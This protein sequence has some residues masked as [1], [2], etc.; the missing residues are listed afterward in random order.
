MSEEQKLQI[1]RAV[2][3]ELNKE[4]SKK[5]KKLPK[6]KIN[7]L[8]PSA[9]VN[10]KANIPQP[11]SV[12]AKLYKPKSVSK[13]FDAQ[14]FAG[15]VPHHKTQRKP[16]KRVHVTQ[17]TTGDSN[18]PELLEYKHMQKFVD[19]WK[20]KTFGKCA[21]NCSRAT[22]YHDTKV[23][24]SCMS[25]WK[26]MLYCKQV[27]W[28]LV[29]RADCHYRF[30]LKEKYWD[31]WRK[32]VS[33][34]KTIIEKKESADTFCRK[35]LLRDYLKNLKSCVALRKEVNANK[36]V[37]QCV[38][39]RNLSKKILHQW[40]RELTSQQIVHEQEHIALHFWS[41]SLQR[42]CLT[43]W[44]EHANQAV[45]KK[46]IHSVV[47]N[48]Y[49][50]KIVHRS[51]LVW[52]KYRQQR[53]C[54]EID[55]KKAVKL[56]KSKLQYKFFYCWNE[57]TYVAIKTKA[58]EQQIRRLREKYKSRN[59]LQ[60]W[61]YYCELR[62]QERNLVTTAD[63]HS[64]RKLLSTVLQRLIE[65]TNHQKET[66]YLKKVALSTRRKSLL[67]NHMAVWL[68]KLD[69]A[70]E[71]KLKFRTLMARKHYQLKILRESVE[72]WVAYKEYR[73]DRKECYE[74]ADA[75]H[76]SSISQLMFTNWHL[77]LSYRKTVKIKKETADIHYF[78]LLNFKFFYTWVKEYRL[79][80]NR[81]QDERIA[82]L[83]FDNHVLTTWFD[84]W[85][86]LS[87]E[88]RD[89]S[90]H[91]KKAVE[92]Y[93]YKL[94]RKGFLGF[95]ENR[96]VNLIK[97]F[98]LNKATLHLRLKL[99]SKCVAA[100]DV[101]AKSRIHGKQ[102]VSMADKHFQQFLKRRKFD[103]WKKH[104]KIISNARKTLLELEN[105]NIEKFLHKCLLHWLSQTKVQK[106]ATDLNLK[107]EFYY[108]QKLKK[109]VLTGWLQYIEQR[110]R[111]HVAKIVL[112]EESRAMLDK[113]Q[114]KQVFAFW[115]NR[116]MLRQ[117]EVHLCSLSDLHYREKIL[118]RGVIQFRNNVEIKFKK[119]ILLKKCN[120]FLIE[121][122]INRSFTRLKFLH[123][124]LVVENSNTEQALWFWLVVFYFNLLII[125]KVIFIIFLSSYFSYII[126]H[127]SLYGIYIYIRLY[128]LVFTF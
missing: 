17:P 85:R 34:N 16:N 118:K 113:L 58:L 20:A 123:S 114:Q 18:Q 56:L 89:D 7:Q 71:N 29:V 80:C 39:N 33:K 120:N 105:K 19:Q 92:H 6:K 66:M 121:N 115:K 111:D 2:L 112:F 50:G 94:I 100:L 106:H 76:R 103:G 47:T 52:I 78:E 35:L 91:Q 82:V 41:L 99:L 62:K 98:Q 122:L 31:N 70:E 45:A 11:S 43:Q 128:I 38:Y 28:K 13:K 127:I 30:Y 126:K 107:A 101:Y 53:K 57:Y 68:S 108:R 44:V 15:K 81:R 84:R 64:T 24:Q 95:S 73:L 54:K 63:A 9:A 83:H 60:H 116:T 88:N 25:Q 42:Q 87:N 3:S 77:Y 1:K 93:R 48:F 67:S 119:I 61:K 4:L 12:S 49:H 26:S 74:I 90:I 96:K 79:S 72:Q 51:F 46:R 109:T 27:E 5:S 102:N 8:Q 65:Y 75:H 110:A 55:K 36:S 104:H 32:F 40:L 21:D 125:D 37:A 23:L 14:T 117:K 10:D 22:V 69:E 97:V 59:I 124:Q 86:V